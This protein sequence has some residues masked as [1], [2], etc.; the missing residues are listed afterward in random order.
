MLRAVPGIPALRQ[1]LDGGLKRLVR[2]RQAPFAMALSVP[3]AKWSPKTAT[4][5]VCASVE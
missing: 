2:L 1:W 5:A 3:R 4:D